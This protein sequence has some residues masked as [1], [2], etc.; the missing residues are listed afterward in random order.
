MKKRLIAVAM[1]IMMMMS[2]SM[3]AVAVSAE[4]GSH[5]VGSENRF[6]Q[7]VAVIGAQLYI[8]DIDGNITTRT[9]PSRDE[10][11]LGIVNQYVMDGDEL[12]MDV[13]ISQLFG[14]EG[15]LYG[16]N[17]DDGTLFVLAN[18][19][20]EYAPV[21]QDLVLDASGLSY[22]M[23][24]YSSM[25]NIK[26][27]F[28]QDTWLYYTGEL[29][30]EGQEYKAGRISLET[31]EHKAFSSVG[32]KELAPYK[33]GNVLAL[34]FDENATNTS[35]LSGYAEN[36]AQIAVFN[37]QNE[38][39]QNPIVLE[40]DT[41]MGGLYTSNLCS[42][43]D[44]AYYFDG[45]RIKGL[46]LETGDIRISAYTGDGEYSG[47][48]L[49]SCYVDGYLFSYDYY[50]MTSRKLDHDNLKDGALVIFGDGGSEPHKTFSK[51]YPDIPVDLSSSNS[52][53][54]DFLTQAMISENQMLDV[55]VLNLSNYPV[56]KLME[57]G[58]CLDLS[59]YP[60]ITSRIETMDSQLLD[61]MIV[62]GKL[63][64]VPVGLYA[65]SFAVNMKTLDEL[66]LTMDDMPT[67]VLELL[68]FVVNWT[69]D[70]GDEHPDIE[71]FEFTLMKDIFFSNILSQYNIY[72]RQKGEQLSYDT[73]EFRQIMDAFEQIDFREFSG[74]DDADFS[75]GHE[76]LF[77]MSHS[78]ANFQ[79]FA[80]PD[81]SNQ[82]IEPMPLSLLGGDDRLIDAAV[83][84][85]VINPKTKRLEQSLTYLTNYLDNLFIYAEHIT[86]F[87]DHND[88]VETQDYQAN[89]KVYSDLLADTKQR[90]TSATQEYHAML[91]ADI[92]MYE[93]DLALLE[94]N[95]YEVT[96]QEILTY[97]ESIAPLLCIQQ[98]QANYGNLFTKYMD[99]TSTVDEMIKDADARLRMMELEE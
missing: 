84:V 66:E 47:M 65:T 37:P 5:F 38:S 2:V 14:Y 88:P 21:R 91:K 29:Y 68:D 63:Y 18:E 78:V 67:S 42:A 44:Q 51:N 98:Y 19:L 90:L 59:G 94:E 76:S 20:G 11:L 50:G 23:G 15:K 82:R 6:V 75:W 83:T 96:A 28:T 27:L 30:G 70:Y 73:P 87:T 99:G 41:T 72:M 61:T 92:E 24:E 64:G 79:T 36:L 43:G 95:R 71:L 81:G 53:D 45:A 52:T 57:K 46:D 93:N 4:T 58:Y 56:D 54:L 34:I 12:T 97:R 89:F 31:G 13:L 22:D 9:A 40:T 25:L 86:L 77:L 35:S 33:D 26:N 60:E 55:L 48:S 1:S 16:L 10:T 74:G 8:L 32:L 7:S 49:K 85:M 62:D 3:P 80:S 17:A 39:L 69:Q